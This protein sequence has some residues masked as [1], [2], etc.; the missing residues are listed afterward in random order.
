MGNHDIPLAIEEKWRSRR[1]RSVDGNFTTNV[2]LFV[3][4]HKWY[5]VYLPFSRCCAVP[6]TAMSC[7]RRGDMTVFLQKVRSHF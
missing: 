4:V 6:Y 1:G 2:S 3:V 5:N 7:S